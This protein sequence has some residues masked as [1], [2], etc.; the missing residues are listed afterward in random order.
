MNERWRALAVLAASLLFAQAARAGPPYVTDDPEPTRTGGWENYA[1][2]SGANTPGETAGEAGVELNYGGA[3]DL[4]LSLDL[5][6]A[7][8]STH[9]FRAGGG[10][11]QASAKYRF[12]R[13][14]EGSL[15]PDVAVFPAVTLPTGAAAFHTGHASY[16]V[17]V[18]AQKDFGKWSVFG[19]GGYDMNP[20]AGQRNYGLFGLALTRSVGKRLNLGVE[21]YH[22]TPQTTGG[23]ALT[24]L[25]VGAIY[26]LTKHWALMASGGPG[27]QAPSRAQAS[28]FYASLQFTN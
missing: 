3:K 1:F 28:T 17:P 5:P 27:L 23:P 2:V 12:I 7:F 11:V 18:W 19:G 15:A 10:D 14:A 6:L 9:S 21:V 8:D 25:G 13:Q 24:N 22:E 20:G 4:Q 16:F 26:Q